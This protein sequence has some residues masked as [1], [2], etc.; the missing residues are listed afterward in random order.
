[1]QGRRADVVVPNRGSR[2][3]RR[4]DRRGSGRTGRLVLVYFRPSSARLFA[5]ASNRRK[6]LRSSTGGP[7]RA[8]LVPDCNRLLRCGM[9]LATGTWAAI[10]PGL[11]KPHQGSSMFK[12]FFRGM[13]DLSRIARLAG[14][15]VLT[16]AM[17]LASATVLTFDDL[18]SGQGFFLSNY[19]GFMF[20]TNNIVTTAWF[21]TDETSTFYAPHSGSVYIATDFQL[22]S[23]AAYEATQ[24][25]SSATPFVFNGAWFSGGETVGYQLYLGIH[26]HALRAAEQRSALRAQRVFGPGH[27]RGRVRTSGLLRAGRLHVHRRGRDR[28]PGTGIDRLARHRAGG[29]RRCCT[30]PQVPRCLIARVGAKSPLRR[31]LFMARGKARWLRGNADRPAPCS[32]PWR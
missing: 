16:C 15:I 6:S 14:A 8:A 31:A 23:G 30:T 11:Q 9:D 19:Q 26:V 21:H 7:D 29:C 12:S 25:I 18:G 17:P 2:A 13:A 27:E 5:I 28:C 20:G 22:Y 3:M 32:S 24:P 4:S 1:M 10:P